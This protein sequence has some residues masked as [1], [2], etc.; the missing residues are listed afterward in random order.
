MRVTHSFQQL[1]HLS[2]NSVSPSIYVHLSMS[3]AM[4]AMSMYRVSCCVCVC[5]A[6]AVCADVGEHFCVYVSL[7]PEETQS[8]LQTHHSTL[9]C[10]HMH[11]CLTGRPVF[12]A[13][14]RTGRTCAC[15]LSFS[16]GA[17]C[18]S[19]VRLLCPSASSVTGTRARVARVRAEYPGQLDYSGLLLTQSVTG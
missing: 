12:C 15:H 16:W 5:V 1:R 11:P 13:V 14:V 2:C 17:L 18:T 6:C 19:S 9:H 7:G 4:L 3:V 8:I 10:K